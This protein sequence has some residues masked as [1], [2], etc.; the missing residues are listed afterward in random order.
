[1]CEDGIEIPS[2]AITVCHHSA[3]LGDP[4]DFFSEGG[5][6]SCPTFTLMMDPYIFRLI[7]GIITL[8]YMY[9]W[10]SKYNP[11]Q[12]KTTTMNRWSFWGFVFGPCCVG[13][14]VVFL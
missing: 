11:R 13:L 2:L 7:Y 12:W 9:P 8:Q 1:M 5:G 10:L 6:G 4:R 14:R 3:S